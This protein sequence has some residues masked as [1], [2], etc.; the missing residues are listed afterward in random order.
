M[1]NEATL[2]GRI[3]KKDTRVLKN[4]GDMT[5]LYIATTRKYADSNG[6]KQEVTTWHNVN[7]FNKLSEIANKYAHVGD[8]VWVRGEIS[9]KKIEHGEKAG[10]WLYAITGS[11]IQLLPSGKKKDAESKPS[12]EKKAPVKK[13]DVYDEFDDSSIP[14]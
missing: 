2:V 10:Q 6:D 11:A 1:I 13:D 14:F 8:L 4:G 12:Q 3:G 9:N 7:F 5:T